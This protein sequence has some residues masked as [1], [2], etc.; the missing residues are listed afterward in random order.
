MKK[1]LLFFCIIINVNI[2]FAQNEITGI[3]MV[4]KHFGQTYSELVETLPV[5]LI[6][7]SRDNLLY[8][9]D[10]PLSN[11]ISLFFINPQ[12]GVN[13]YVIFAH[14]DRDL[15]N[16][17]AYLLNIFEKSYGNYNDSELSVF[18]NSNLP[19]NVS[20]IEISKPEADIANRNI[21]LIRWYGY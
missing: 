19:E 5:G 9:Y 13:H 7:E 12:R 16:Y 15:K 2:L 14:A 8:V 21:I 4:K 11:Y 3:T 10:Y 6:T 1:S 18:F 20:K 17:Y